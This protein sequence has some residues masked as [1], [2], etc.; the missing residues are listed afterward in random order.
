MKKIFTLAALLVPLFILAQ[1][2]GTPQSLTPQQRNAAQQQLLNGNDT[3]NRVY[4]NTACGLNYVKVTERLG[5]RFLPTGV[6]QPAA[7]AVTGM[8]VC[9][10]VDTAFVWFELLGTAPP[11]PIIT[12][13][14]PQGQSLVVQSQLIGSSIDVCWS[15]NGTHVY[16]ADV[17]SI[18]ST[19]GVYTISGIP[20]DST[21]PAANTVDSEGATLLIVYRDPTVSYTGTLLIDDG[22]ATVAGGALN[23]TMTGISSCS[24]SSY[25]NAFMLAGDFQFDDIMN[26]NGNGVPFTFNWWNDITDT[27]VQITSPQTTFSY[28]MNSAGDCYT[29]AV[30]GLYFQTSC[31]SCVAVSNPI[32]FNSV[33]VP[34]TCNSNGSIALSNITGGTGPYSFTWSTNP[35]QTTSTVSNLAPGNYYVQINGVSGCGG[36]MITVPY[37]GVTATLAASP[38]SCGNYMI[39]PSVTG[40]TPPYT[41]LWMPGNQTTATLNNINVTGAY[42]LIVTDANGCTYTTSPL[43]LYIGMLLNGNINTT[44]SYCPNQGDATIYPYGGSPPYSYLWSTN[45]TTQA[46]QNLSPGTYSVTITDASGCTATVSDSVGGSAGLQ[47]SY[48]S[49]PNLNVS[50]HSATL[51]GVLANDYSATM[52]WMPSGNTLTSESYSPTAI[53][54]DTIVVMAMNACDT[55][56]HSFYFTVNNN[57]PQAPELC[58]VSVDPSSNH[59][60]VAWDNSL[61][62]ATDY[63]DIYKEVPYNS[64]NFTLLTTQQASVVS[65][66]IDT[67]SDASVSPERYRVVQTD[68]CGG[69]SPASN[70]HAGISLSITPASPQGSLLTWTAYQ[71]APLWF[72]YVYRGTSLSNMTL[73]AQL[74]ATDTFYLDTTA[75]SWIYYVEAYPSTGPCYVQRLA[76]AQQTASAGPIRSNIVPDQFVGITEAP[77]FAI[78][79]SPN[80]A[81]GQFTVNFTASGV[82]Q[83]RVFDVT[84]REVH[85][86]QLNTGSG[87]VNTVLDLRNLTPGIYMLQISSGSTVS[88]AKLVIR[89]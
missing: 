16:R 34:A 23:H 24:S 46:V 25:G 40:G 70:A 37:A 38:A 78:G 73:L 6:P 44:P 74:T 72:Q 89:R 27:T 3:L 85:R 15:M 18:I 30:A 13:T 26:F 31:M 2:D 42:L 59:Y 83:L 67:A 14:N 1:A 50:C 48:V 82:S 47:W 57:P 61:S 7:L 11:A 17:T 36:G 9:S 29:F 65:F 39:T 60:L 19:N 55:I 81:D 75:G 20:V 35:V 76:A 63:F 87:N 54:N 84:G 53:G 4:V 69:V 51:L 86:E 71:G 56:S 21:A 88:T 22:A 79:I 10:A 12:L 45:A 33:V 52:L 62:A 49:S 77:A 64:N 32:N 8:P 68:V 28:D 5:Q 43:A 41:Y 66:F 80:P 58:G